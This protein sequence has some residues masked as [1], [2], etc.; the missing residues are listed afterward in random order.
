MGQI[1]EAYIRKEIEQDYKDFYS[2]RYD[3]YIPPNIVE[4]MRT[5]LFGMC[6]R[7]F[8]APPVLLKTI[9]GKKDEDL[10]FVDMGTIVN[11]IF[12]VPLNFLH[13]T[14]EEGLDYTELLYKMQ[15]DFNQRVEAF[16]KS[17]ERKQK[18]LMDLG[19]LTN[20]IQ[21]PSIKN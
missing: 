20:A 17:E 3:G 6:P 21:M 14:L 12:N 15:E 4:K 18:R 11:T 9:I 19:G 16:N 7:N 1:T 2:K 13:E 8:Q 5:S 10:S